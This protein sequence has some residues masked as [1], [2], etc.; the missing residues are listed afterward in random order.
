M[1]PQLMEHFSWSTE[2]LTGP[3]RSTGLSS[4]SGCLCYCLRNNYQTAETPSNI[5]PVS[6]P[7]YTPWGLIAKS[8]EVWYEWGKRSRSLCMNNKQGIYTFHASSFFFLTEMRRKASLS[9]SAKPPGQSIK[10]TGEKEVREKY[11]TVSMKVS[12]QLLCSFISFFSILKPKIWIRKANRER[13][14]G[15]I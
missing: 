2:T 15:E 10:N 11:N 8:F 9:G 1:M 13:K 6:A 7:Q 12:L 14:E 3:T 5:S 4:A